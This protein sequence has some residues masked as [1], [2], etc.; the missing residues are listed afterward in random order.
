[1]IIVLFAMN[2]LDTL[3]PEY[4]SNAK[5]IL[6]PLI[7]QLQGIKNNVLDKVTREIAAD[8]VAS[9][10]SRIHNEGKAVDGSEIGSYAESTKKQRSKKGRQTQYKDLSFTGKLSKEFSFAAVGSNTIGVGFISDY[11]ADLS[12]I[13][14]QREGKKIWGATQKDERVAEQVAKNRIN[15]Y[16]NG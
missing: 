1:M 2:L 6:G 9:N 16:L 8:L 10:I 14:E 13:H 3:M 4:K 7:N 15:K 12:E 11:G 5:N